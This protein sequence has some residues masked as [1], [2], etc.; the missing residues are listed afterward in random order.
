MRA[1]LPW[2]IKDWLILLAAAM[3]AAAAFWTAGESLS[4]QWN[5]SGAFSYM[6]SP[7]EDGWRSGLLLQGLAASA[8]LL[9]YAGVLSLLLGGLLAAALLSPARSAAV[10]LVECVR[11]LP[12]IV[13]IFIFFYFAGG[14]VAEAAG[15]GKFLSDNEGFWTGLLAGDARTAD[16][17]VVGVVCL[18]LFEAAFFAEIFRA[19]VLS[20]DAGQR[21]AAR[22]LGFGRWRTMRLVVAPQALRNAAAPLAGQMVLLV[23]DSAIL[24]VISAPEL[25][26]SAQEAAASSRH[27]FEIWLIA[28]ALYFMLC[29]PLLRLA[30]RLERRYPRSDR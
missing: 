1:A 21:E 20:V 13:F 22:S 5:W 9:L 30:A 15:L 27:V 17:F 14:H 28:A 29:W 16:N 19:G 11:G 2:G 7:G 18:A 3:L 10:C 4:Y 23:K 26:F 25:T 24:S 8:R 6:V 12:P